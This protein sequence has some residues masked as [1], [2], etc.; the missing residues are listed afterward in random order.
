MGIHFDLSRMEEVIQN[1]ERWWKGELDRPLIHGIIYDAYSTS[2]TTELPLLSQANC[3][4]LSRSPEEIIEAYDR[5]LSKYEF[6]GDGYPHINMDVFGPGVVAAFCGA[7][8]DNSSGR[9][10]FFPEEEK[11][12]HEIHVKYDPDNI[13][14]RRI[15]DIYRAGLE[16]WNGSV[17]MG[18]PDLGGVLDIAASL[19][20]SE[21]LLF[22]LLDEPGEVHRLREEIHT[23]WHEAYNDFA[24]VLMAQGGYSDW[25]LLLSKTP[26]YILQSDFSYMIS[27]AMFEEFVIDNLREDTQRLSHTIYHLDGIGELRHLDSI[28]SL[29]N[30]NAVQWVYGDGQPGPMHWLEDVYRKIQKAGKQIMI[31]GGAEEYLDT[32]GELHGSPYSIQWFEEKD[33]DFAMKLLKAR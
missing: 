11:E 1:H 33:R 24:N 18:M 6:I 15:K 7:K 4:D 10:W 13:W 20:G 29:K 30:L 3:N 31:M 19:Y 16:R 5:Q 22:A 21:E 12:I 25:S 26:S 23:A 28:L 9:V 27:P 17:I 8:L 14:S 2:Q 32:L